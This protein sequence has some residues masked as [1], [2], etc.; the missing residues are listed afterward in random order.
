MTMATVTV[1]QGI[2]TF[3]EDRGDTHGD[4]FLP[5]IQMAEPADFHSRPGV[6]LKGPLL[7]PPNEHH[8]PQALSFNLTLARVGCAIR[9]GWFAHAPFLSFSDYGHVLNSGIIKVYGGFGIRA[10]VRANTGPFKCSARG[11]S[12]QCQS[13]FGSKPL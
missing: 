7:K 6:F 9:T 8:H 5:A 4:R 12:L 11:L 13:D 1:H 3:I 10:A 2:L